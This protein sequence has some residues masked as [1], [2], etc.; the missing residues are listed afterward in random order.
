MACRIWLTSS[1]PSSWLST[2]KSLIKMVFQRASISMPLP[3]V[4]PAGSFR[5]QHPSP[6][7]ET[8]GDGLLETSDRDSAGLFKR[9]RGK[10]GVEEGEKTCLIATHCTPPS[11]RYLI[12]GTSG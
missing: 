12:G 5:G 7:T 10:Q 6:L 3:C 2:H 1:C 9:L 11:S 4:F 8:Y